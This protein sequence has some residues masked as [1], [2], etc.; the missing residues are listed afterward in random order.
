[1][2]KCGD[3]VMTY[4]DGRLAPTDACE[5]LPLHPQAAHFM[6]QVLSRKSAATRLAMKEALER[7]DNWYKTECDQW[8]DRNLHRLYG[9]TAEEGD[10]LRAADEAQA[11]VDAMADSSSEE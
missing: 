7:Y 3:P 9:L 1:M 6:A 2:A 11:R 4:E 5:P 10:A 8:V